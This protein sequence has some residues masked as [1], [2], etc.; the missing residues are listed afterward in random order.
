M[1]TTDIA[2]VGGT[3]PGMSSGLSGLESD[4]SDYVAGAALNTGLGPRI[5]ANGRFD[6]ADF[7]INR[8]EI[9]ATA[10]LGPVSASAAY[11]YLRHNPYSSTLASAS[12]VRGA[13]SVNLTDNWRA[14]GSVIYDINGNTVAGDGLGLAFDNDCLT[15]SVAYNENARRLH[16]R[17]AEPLADFPPA[18]AHPR[19][20][21]VS[22]QPEQRRN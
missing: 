21:L 6:N 12:V 4:R 19:R 16:R 22:D 7:A 5:S 3:V 15:F 2:G 20:Q 1:P 8:G 17:R 11:L 10:A 18:A 9:E 13:A 14:F